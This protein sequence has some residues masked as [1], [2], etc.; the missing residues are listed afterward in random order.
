MLDA[1]TVNVVVRSDGL[2]ELGAN[3]HTRTI[4]GRTTREKH[5]PGTRVGESSL[6]SISLVFMAPRAK[7]TSSKETA[8]LKATPVH[9][10]GLLSCST[11]QGSLWSCSKM[12][13]SWNSQAWTGIRNLE[14]AGAGIG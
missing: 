12:L 4:G 8:T 7:L 9:L 2:S 3:D 6:S 10:K 14:A 11:G 13:V 5:Y 1:V